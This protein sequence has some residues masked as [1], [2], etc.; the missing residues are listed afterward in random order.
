MIRFESVPGGTRVHVR[1]A[2]NPPG[3]ALGHIAAMLFG[4]DPK[5]AMDEDLIRIKSL[6][7]TGKASAPGK[8]VVRDRPMCRATRKQR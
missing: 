3:G 4:A 8:E 7:E 6:I 2:Y 5:S 1:L